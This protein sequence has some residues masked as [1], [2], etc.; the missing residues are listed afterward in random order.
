VASQQR[1]LCSRRPTENRFFVEKPRVHRRVKRKVRKKRR[2]LDERR[3]QGL[4]RIRGHEND[5]RGWIAAQE[6]ASGSTGLNRWPLP[7]VYF[8]SSSGGSSDVLH[9]R[10]SALRRN[11]CC[12]AAAREASLLEEIWSH[13]DELTQKSS[14][15]RGKIWHLSL[16]SQ[17]KYFTG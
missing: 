2:V 16:L 5:P 12:D 14:R 11:A 8:E 10:R 7:G 6:D 15:I 9:L 17:R 4:Q 1:C 3:R 13:L